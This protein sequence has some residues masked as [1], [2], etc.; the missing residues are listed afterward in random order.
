[1]NDYQLIQQ[2]LPFIASM[3]LALSIIFEKGNKVVRIGSWAILSWYG[4]TLILK[5]ITVSLGE[6]GLGIAE[7]YFWLNLIITPLSVI[8]LIIGM[9]I[10]EE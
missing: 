2:A 4:L 6:S 10:K 8:I 3:L 1:M 5:A 9:C 7:L